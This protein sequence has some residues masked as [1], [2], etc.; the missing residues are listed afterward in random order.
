MELITERLGFGFGLADG[1]MQLIVAEDARLGRVTGRRE[2]S[3]CACKS[4]FKFSGISISDRKR[5]S[6]AMKRPA[7]YDEA[8]AV[9]I[10]QGLVV[11]SPNGFKG[12]CDELDAAA[13]GFM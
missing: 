7:Q 12:A 2:R 8:C 6:S 5:S 1:V 13:C 4:V 11:L 9:W 3:A 10:W